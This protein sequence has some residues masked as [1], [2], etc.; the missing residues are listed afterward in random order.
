MYTSPHQAIKSNF[1]QTHWQVNMAFY[2]NLPRT[3]PIPVG[4]KTDLADIDAVKESENIFEGNP[5][6]SIVSSL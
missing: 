1:V 2:K 3:T 5:E 6:N 4:P